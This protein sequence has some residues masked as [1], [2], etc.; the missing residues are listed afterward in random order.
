MFA[1]N[2]CMYMV[3]GEIHFIESGCFG[4]YAQ[5]D[6]RK[7]NVFCT[8]AL[9]SNKSWSLVSAL[10]RIRTLQGAGALLHSTRD[11]TRFLSGRHRSASSIVPRKHPPMSN[12][13][14]ES[15]LTSYLPLLYV[16]HFAATI[17]LVLDQWYA[18]C[19]FYSGS[20]REIYVQG[21]NLRTGSD[22]TWI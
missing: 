9:V 11:D 7:T 3:E 12:L 2:A 16:R 6:R 4:G 17:D 13:R 10:W 8:L 21:V 19:Y 22:Q 20:I 5:I 14:G 18:T 1:E 15:E